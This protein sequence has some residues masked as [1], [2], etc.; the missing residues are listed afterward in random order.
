MCRTI[1]ASPYVRIRGWYDMEP[2]G[3]NQPDPWFIPG[4]LMRAVVVSTRQSFP[5]EYE[6][7][8]R[9]LVDFVLVLLQKQVHILPTV[10]QRSLP[11]RLQLVKCV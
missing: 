6:Q 1:N 7:I 10:K 3:H 5:I 9:W 2:A 8:S 4:S 11:A